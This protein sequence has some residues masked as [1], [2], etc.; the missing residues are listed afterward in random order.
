MKKRW[1][2]VLIVV[3]VVIIIALCIIGSIVAPEFMSWPYDG[4][5]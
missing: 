4:T 2:V 5:P 1:R 3:G